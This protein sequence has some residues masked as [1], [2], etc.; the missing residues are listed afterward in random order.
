MAYFVDTETSCASAEQSHSLCLYFIVGRGKA[1]PR[2]LPDRRKPR[3]TDL[4][5][6]EMAT[7]TPRTSQMVRG[8]CELHLACAFFTEDS[9]GGRGPGTRNSGQHICRDGS[10]GGPTC[11]AGGYRKWL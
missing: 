2:P 3:T 4:P 7:G 6:A 1:K 5:C 11:C 8:G 9:H 10:R